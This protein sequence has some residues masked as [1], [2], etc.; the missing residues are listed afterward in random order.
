METIIIPNV[1][2]IPMDH[3]SKFLGHLVESVDL[4]RDLTKRFTEA[5]S[6]MTDGVDASNFTNQH[7][8]LVEGCRKV[9]EEEI[10]HLHKETFFDVMSLVD[11][12]SR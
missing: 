1:G 10:A 8:N 2:K 11:S 5:K 3:L 4:S 9:F 12:I 6:V 7:S